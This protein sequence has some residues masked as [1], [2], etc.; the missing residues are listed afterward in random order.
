MRNVIFRMAAITVLGLL[1]RSAIAQLSISAQ[2]RARSEFRDGQG[3]PLS[4]EA[5][6]ALFISQRTRLTGVFNNPRIKVGISL[7]DV[8]TWGQDVSTINRNTTENNNGFMLH[9]AWAEILLSDT[10]QKNSSLNLRLGRQELVY[11]DQRLIGNLDWLQQ[12]RRHDAAVLK[13]QRKN[14]MVHLGGAFNQNKENASGTIY[15]SVPAGNYPAST[16]NGT[17]YK[18]M[19]F[20]YAGKKLAKGSMSYL[21]FSDQFSKYSLE[22]VEGVNVKKFHSGTWTRFT[23][24]VYFNNNFDKLSVSASGYHQFGKNSSG[25]NLKAW[26][27]ALSGG[28]QIGKVTAGAGVDYT[29]G[30]AP[31]N[32]NKTFDPLY[33]TPHKFWGF[34]DYFYA[35]SG[36]GN[37]GLV[38]YFANFKWKNSD[39]FTLTTVIHH[40]TSQN[41]IATTTT[42]NKSFGQE[43]DIVAVYEIT[44][45]IA[46]EGGYSHFFNTALLAD[47]SVKNI[48]NFKTGANWAYIMINIKPEF[49]FK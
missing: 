13:F 7:Q 4:K 19:Q 44:K 28:Y 18:S 47:P 23:T 10:A 27:L 40:F 46:L 26:L 22:L 3:A 36:F 8:R 12:A 29:S 32:T 30:S 34:M 5:D 17:M 11:D 25:Q 2:V 6:P 24:G 39:R 41:E 37:A 16:N 9:E 15:S 35:G 43:V 21:F 49:L 38:D 48:S 42:N 1:S 14:I 31:G 45:Q 33:G 20:L